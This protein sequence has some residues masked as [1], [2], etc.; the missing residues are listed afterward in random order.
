SISASGGGSYCPGSSIPLSSTSTGVTNRYWTGPN[1][2]YSTSADSTISS[3][4]T[5]MSGTYTVTGNAESGNNLVINGNFSLGNNDFSSSYGYAADVSGNSELNPEGLYSITTIGYNVHNN[6]NSIPDHTNDAAR[7]QMIVNGSTSPGTNVWSETLPV[8]SNV[9]YQFSYWVQTVVNGTDANP[10]QLQLFV[11]GLA[12]GPIKTAI[13]TSGIWTQFIYN[14][15]SGGN[16]TAVLS[17]VNQNTIAGGNDFALDDIKFQ[18]VYYNSA[19][20]DVTVATSYSVSVI[21]AASSNPSNEGSTVTF[22]ATPTNGGFAPTYQWKVNGANVGTNSSTYSYVPTNGDVV[23]C[24]LTSSLGCATPNPATN[25]V[26]MVVNA[27]PANLWVG[28]ISTDWSNA[29]NWSTN[30]IPASGQDVIFAT[31][32][33]HGGVPAAR[34]LYLDTDRTISNLINQ[35]TNRRLVI[36]PALSLTVTN[37]ITTSNI[38]SL[39][40]IQAS[41]NGSQPNGSLIF[42]NSPSSPVHGTVEMYSK[43]TWDLTQAVNSKYNWQYFGI[44]LRTI[45]TA[46]PTFNFAYVRKWVESGTDINNHWIALTDNDPLSSFIGYELCQHA[47]KI[48][49]FSGILENGDY[50]ATLAYTVSPAPLYPGQ[51]IYANPYTAA[52]DITMLSFGFDTEKTIYMYNTGTYGIWE[53]S[54]GG[55]STGYYENPGQYYAI[56]QSVAGDA[57]LQGKIPSMQAILVKAMSPSSNA[58]FGITYNSVI[59]KNTFIQ[60]VA[61]A[62]SISTSDKISLKIN[63]KSKN[64]TD[65]MWIFTNSTSTYGFDNGWD[66]QKIL[67]S[68]LAP[69]LYSIEKDGNYQVNTVPDMNNTELA[70]QAGQDVEDTLTFTNMNLEKQYAGVYLVDLLENRTIDITTSG[71]QYAFMAES[72]PSPV[73]RFKIVTRPYEKNAPDAETQ[74]K[75]F[76]AGN[77]IFVQNFGSA[78]GECRVYDIAGHYLM[79][80]PFSS[81]NVTTITNSLKPGA[82]IATAIAGGEKVSKRLIVQ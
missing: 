65:F 27:V 39:I 48:Y 70:F 55:T 51:N 4:T 16:T 73:T 75:V 38:D 31:A 61:S 42:H 66:G 29:N 33:N 6:F 81:N 30:T 45:D 1:N 67:G 63:V 14:W 54:G 19:S 77:S 79:K 53:S 50:S 72:T 58:T 23:S 44:P 69:Q 25:S 62:D 3:A 37:T 7:L 82:Y 40:Y 34:D 56:P 2:F 80:V 13:A 76:S 26:T 64:F 21:V 41:A 17:L 18:Q 74:V 24:S 36:P 59:T 32:A 11:N 68:A 5:A 12:A 20:V 52:I 57:G 46:S 9:D 47:Q 49:K 8:E 35:T 60:R 78:D 71:T 43:A 15:S 22:T 10:A 28:S